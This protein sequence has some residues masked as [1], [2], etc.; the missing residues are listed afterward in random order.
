MKIRPLLASES[1][2]LSFEFFPPKS[3]GGSSKLFETIKELIPYDPSFVSVTYGAGG[4]TR[5]LTH[6]LV[7]NIH[8]KTDLN[9]M[10]HLTC[11]GSTKDEIFAILK[12]YQDIG[13]CNIMA[14]RGDLPKDSSINPFPYGGFRYAGELVHFIKEHFP[15]FCVGVAGFPEGHP[16]T[17]N[18]LKEIEYLKQKMDQGADF[19]CSQLFFD[20]NDFYDFKER[21]ALNG[22]SCPIVAGIM[23]IISKSGYIRMA[24]LAGGAR[25]PSKLLKQLINANDA[26]IHKIGEEWAVNQVNDLI[27]QKVSGV[28]LYTLNKSS[29]SIRV[30]QQTSLSEKSI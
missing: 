3:E 14:L 25:Y 15:D 16:E 2:N 10:A 18:R 9:I 30:I 13:I 12:R 28:H 22:I 23:P 24:D 19:I 29:S 21:A 5:D 6:D 1:T 27:Q 17:P 11:I 26:D 8:K 20:N 4:A 7:E